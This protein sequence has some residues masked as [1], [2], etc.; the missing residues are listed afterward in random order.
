MRALLA[1]ALLA[2]CGTMPEA[3]TAMEARLRRDALAV[4]EPLT[5]GG[6][7][8][9]VRAALARDG[10]ATR[11]HD[12]DTIE[13]GEPRPVLFVA[14]HDAS[15]GVTGLLR[16]LSHGVIDLPPITGGAVENAGGV[17]VGLE[18]ARCGRWVVFTGAHNAGHLGAHAF[19]R[20]LPD[21]AWPRCVIV[22][23]QLGASEPIAFAFDGL[24]TSDGIAFGGWAPVSALLTEA[25]WCLVPG[26]SW[27]H[28]RSTRVIA[29]RG[30]PD[31][32]AADQWATI[33]QTA[34]VGVSLPVTRYHGL[35]DT[36]AQLEPRWLALAA[37]RAE[38]LE[39]IEQ[40]R[41]GD[42]R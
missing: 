10:V 37:K 11:E 33:A 6:R 31:G 28:W 17:A 27:A 21:A 29:L 23:A 8:D 40:L 32:F 18:L 34:A 7:A 5:N 2:G 41:S 22:L 35:A 42:S 30:A 13:A 4:C 25:P 15:D 3:S 12:Y 19:A 1:L 39:M 16:L 24:D 26:P 9:A 14:W 36:P 38:V 20:S